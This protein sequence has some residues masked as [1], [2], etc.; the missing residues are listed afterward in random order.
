MSFPDGYNE[1]PA[2][3]DIALLSLNLNEIFPLARLF[4]VIAFWK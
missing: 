3:L 1:D 4:H 2:V